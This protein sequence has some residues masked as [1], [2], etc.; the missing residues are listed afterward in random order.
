MI[1]QYFLLCFI[2]DVRI[3]EAFHLFDRGSIEAINK[4]QFLDAC[5]ALGFEG[6]NEHFEQLF[7][8]V[9]TNNDNSIGFQA[10]QQAARSQFVTKYFFCLTFSAF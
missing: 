3:K 1:L 8:L 5:H 6:T 7:E 4:N 9:D 10:F 2:Q